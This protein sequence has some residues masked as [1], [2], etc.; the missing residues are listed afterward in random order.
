[1]LQKPPALHFPVL[2]QGIFLKYHRENNLKNF[3]KNKQKYGLPILL[4]GNVN[5]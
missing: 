3:S 5:G 2:L 4:F 1:L